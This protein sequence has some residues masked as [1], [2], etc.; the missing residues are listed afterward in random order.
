[1][2]INRRIERSAFKPEYQPGAIVRRPDTGVEMVIPGGTELLDV[3]AANLGGVARRQGR[4]HSRVLGRALEAARYVL[5]FAFAC[6]LAGG[7]FAVVR[8][9]RKS[10]S[11]ARSG[12]VRH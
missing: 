3:A 12:Q 7:L 11:F 2:T 4:E 9:A 5:T 6:A 10:S 8:R 1:M